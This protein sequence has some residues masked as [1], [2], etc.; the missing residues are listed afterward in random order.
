MWLPVQQLIAFG[1]LFL[2]A[3]PALASPVDAGAPAT[4]C[5]A[6][7]YR[8]PPTIRLEDD[9]EPIV[10][11]VL[12]YSPTFRQQCR[13]LAAAPTLRATVQLRLRR[14]GSGEMRARASFRD[15]PSGGVIATIE[16]GDATVLTELLAHEFEHVIERLDGVDLREMARHGEARQLADGAFETRR[17][18]LAGLRVSGEVVD[19]TPDRLRET[20][21]SI[22]RAMW[23]WRGGD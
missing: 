7:I 1:S 2:V 16:L 20:T 10:R 4:I 23:R 15:R 6:P 13:I 9:L 21:G 22:W 3:P 5:D 17:A 14:P 11:R 12:E 8:L 18:I 19:N